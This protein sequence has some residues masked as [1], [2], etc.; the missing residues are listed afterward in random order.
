MEIE[1]KDW[2]DKSYWTRQKRYL[3]ADGK[4]KIY[5][6]PSLTWE[7]FDAIADTLSKILPKGK[8]LDVGCGAG[9]LTHRLLRRGFDAYGVDIS[10]YAVENCHPEMRGRLSLADISK[11][12]DVGGPFDS[13]IATDLL[14]H[15]YAEDL[16]ETF[17]WMLD[18][19]KR[20]MFF[21]VA[22]TDG[23]NFV[24]KKGAPVPLRWQETAV[25]GHVNVKNWQYWVK[26]FQTKGLK[27][28]WDLG[29]IFQL[30]REKHE[31]WRNTGG[32]SLQT[33]WVL[34]KKPHCELQSL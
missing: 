34:E 15:L 7:G 16:D 32:W 29:Y 12:P 11:K 13:V 24:H 30:E 9:D 18:N 2:Y 4:E 31:G 5:S 8:L 19:T 22:V 14:E 21:C 17:Q 26:Y 10:K 20:W 1:Y 6:G 25:S 23:E 27:V 33:T 28:R 3:G